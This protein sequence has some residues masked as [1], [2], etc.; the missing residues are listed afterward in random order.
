METRPSRLS[1]NIVKLD[2]AFHTVILA[3]LVA[4]LLFLAT[5]LAGALFSHPQT[6]WLLW[7]GCAMLVSV[8]LLL[9]QRTWPSIIPAAFAA[10]VLCDLQAGVPIG[11]VAW[12]ILADT[13]QVLIAALCLS[14]FFGGVPRLNSVAA[15]SKYSFFAVVLAPYAAAFLSAFGIPG[16]YWTS[17]R[18]SFLSEVLAFVALPPTILGWLSDGPTWVR[19]SHAYHVEFAA[20]ISGLALLSYITFT[21]SGN[22]SPALLYSLVPFLLWAALRFGSLGVSTSVCVIAFLSIWGAVHG[23]GPFTT[24]GLFNSVF[25]L[26]LFLVFTATPFMV[27][28][29]LVEERKQAE[30]A[31][32]QSETELM[33]AQRLANVGSWRWDPR[34]DTVTWSEELYRIAG[35]DPGLPAVSYKEHPKLYTA[36][37]WDRLRRAVEEA[38][39]TGTPYELDLEMIRIDGARRWLIAKGEVRRDST[40]HIVQ[41]RGTVH[42]ITE[43]K[44]TEEALRES[45][46]RER[47]KVKELE[48]LL[49]AAPITILIA[50]DP[51]CKFITAN[52][53]GSQLHHVPIGTN[54]S[55][56]A[57]AVG[58]PL[59]FRIMRDGIE[60]PVGELPLQRAAATGIPVIGTFSTLVLEDGTERHMIGNTAPLFDEDG[61]PRGAVGAFVDITDRKRA[62]E[63]LRESEERLRLAV[64]AGRM[65][66][67]ERDAVTDAIVRSGQCADILNWMNDPTRDTGRQFVARVH[68]DDREAY[69]ATEAALTP[70]NPTYKTSYRMLR[71]DGDLIW[72]EESGRG[73]F[74]GKGG[75]LRMIGLVADVTER[76]LAEEAISSVSRRLIEAQEQER[77]RIARELHDDLSQRMALLQIGLEQFER[78]MPGLSSRARQQLHD[79]AEASAEVSSSIHDLSYRLHPSKLDTLGLVASIR[80]FCREFSQ[81]HKLGVLFVHHDIQEEIPKDVSLCLYRIVEEA[82]QNILKH[83]GA[84]DAKVELSGHSNRIDL[85]VS[86]SGTGFTPESVRAEVGIGLISMRERLRLVGGHISIESGPSVGTQIRVRIP[87]SST[88]GQRANEQSKYK[89]TA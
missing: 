13:V 72:L 7:P 1:W 42:D 34:T 6:I 71:P 14:Y 57:P 9:P 2:S 73:F 78:N 3:C 52:R 43:R 60:I 32:R 30:Q 49:D 83:S 36:E 20:L 17:W 54:F 27:L 21:A 16:P 37:S 10:F 63:A 35:L 11:S 69:A 74:D 33:K 25:S 77:A 15:L 88:T 40:G 26:Q 67:F 68:P 79:L 59:P 46:G 28:A 44:R 31:L 64:Q 19:K 23:R 50:A 58:P 76:K 45:E 47:A 18:I 89:A 51:E 55:K 62:E 65:Y 84:E 38:L 29:A 82:L 80:G 41:L 48:T 81:C 12:F 53:T 75:L 70:Q 22:S 85:C 87:L 86:D 66:V 8:L 5:T 56:S 24:G 39:R 4:L 61:K